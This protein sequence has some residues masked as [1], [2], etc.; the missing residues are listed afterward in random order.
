MKKIYLTVFLAGS[1]GGAV[2][3]Q[4]SEGGFPRSMS[5]ENNSVSTQQISKALFREPDYAQLLRDDEADAKAGVAKPY[6]VA[7]TVAADLDISNS[8]TWAY[9]EDGSKIWR[10]QVQVPGA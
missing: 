10:L 9:L 2:H 3:A 4:K 1:M 5:L 8:G 6:R 7:A